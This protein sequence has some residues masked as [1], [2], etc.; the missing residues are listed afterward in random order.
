MLYN[1]VPCN[2]ANTRIVHH[3]RCYESCSSDA[4]LLCVEGPFIVTSCQLPSECLVTLGC[5]LVLSSLWVVDVSIEV[6]RY[7][8]QGGHVCDHR[9]SKPFVLSTASTNAGAQALAHLKEVRPARR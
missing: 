9:L 2:D 8:L 3:G 1:R 6:E 7:L 4:I 5:C